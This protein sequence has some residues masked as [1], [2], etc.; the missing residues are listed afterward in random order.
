MVVSQIDSDFLRYL[1]DQGFEPGKRLPA[2]AQ[3]SAEI[4]V[5]VGKLREQMEIAR[6]LG[7]IEASPRRG[8]RCLDVDFRPAVRLGLMMALAMDSGQFDAFG[9]LR[10]HIETA[11]WTEAVSLLNPADHERLLSLCATATEKLQR[12]R[13]QIPHLEH[14]QFHLSIF[15]RLENPFVLGLLEAYWDAYEAVELNTYADYAYLQAVWAYHQRIAEAIAAGELER[16]RELLIAHMHLLELRGSSVP[17]SPA[18][19][20]EL[21][22]V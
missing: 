22:A 3:I 11:Y 5:S 9:G 1:I 7:L 15:R 20:E 2:L 16:G 17:A 19:L 18:R 13:V 6:V 21:A 8:I 12:E 10:A 14:R 4:G